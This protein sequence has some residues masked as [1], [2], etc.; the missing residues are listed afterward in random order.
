M[1]QIYVQFSDNSEAEIISYFTCPQD[2]VVWPNQGTVDANDTRWI[3]YC[4][5]LP[6]LI[7]NTIQPS[8]S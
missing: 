1:S 8:E 4:A 6:A 5:S 3:T 2:P 7:R